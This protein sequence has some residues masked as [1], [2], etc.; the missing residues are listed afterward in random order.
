MAE[1]AA[2]A[3][4][5]GLDYVVFLE[6]FE[7]LTKDEY[8]ELVKECDKHSDAE[9]EL[10]PGFRIR[11]NIGNHVM[12]IA[13]SGCWP[14][15][16][17]LGEDGRAMILQPMAEDGTYDGLKHRPTFSYMLN[18]TRNGDRNC[19]YYN[20]AESGKG[21]RMPAQRNCAMAGLLYYREG[22][23]VEDMLDDYL[24]T[25]QST[26]P[27]TPVA[28][29][30]VY[31]PQELIEEVES[32]HALTYA[33]A[34]DRASIMRDALRWSG[35]YYS[36]NVFPSSGPVIRAWPGTFRFMTYGGEEFVTA[37]AVMGS[38]LHVTSDKGLKQ[39]TIYDGVGVFRRFDCRGAR[40]FYRLLVLDGTVMKNLIVVAE[41]TAGGRA[42]SFTRRSYKYDIR[43]LS[44]CGDHFNDVH[45]RMAHGSTPLPVC[46]APDLPWDIAGSTW[47]GGPP[48]R[49]P[50]VNFYESR[51]VLATD[52]GRENGRR[53]WQVPVAE[54]SDE[55]LLAVASEANEL[56]SD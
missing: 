17:V 1:Y 15:D 5:A 30:E 39:I 28:V 7:D 36:P 37:P 20:W 12:C 13:E 26:M 11:N 21:M 53:Y 18:H 55:G 10:I 54:T 31:S 51:P 52:K 24:V 33:Q 50:L 44:W 3:K 35:T 34:R 25:S 9:V 23:L 46:P 38:P 2:A 8:E 6:D 56:M 16:D 47:D 14:D 45:M 27:P 32:G 4:K 41:D 43:G 29:N 22:E 42:V 49:L 19:G 40:E 48:A